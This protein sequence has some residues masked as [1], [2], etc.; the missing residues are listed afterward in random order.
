MD[1]E[2]K[3]KL[4]R[5][6]C[7]IYKDNNLNIDITNLSLTHINNNN[8]KNQL[9]D[10]II[11]IL[12]KL[13][14]KLI[15][16]NKT[17]VDINKV[18]QLFRNELDLNQYS[19]SVIKATSFSEKAKKYT[20]PAAKSKLILNEIRKYFNQK[21]I[22]RKNKIIIDDYK[23]IEKYRYQWN[24]KS[25]VEVYSKTFNKWCLGEIINIF[26]DNEGEWLRV[27]YQ[28]KQKSL[29]RYNQ[30]IRPIQQQQINNNNNN[31]KRRGSIDHRNDKSYNSY[32]VKKD[33]N[34]N[35]KSYWK[36]KEC[37][38]LNH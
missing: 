28:N 11:K 23:D 33:D 18:I 15:E 38:F 21:E 27:K 2:D 14:N 10:T 12:K 13:N 22:K 20:I 4:Y 8:K 35:N 25:K 16:E 7:Q 34:N 29:Q 26:Q 37:G 9:I 36:C 24:I 30:Q 5:I 19:L 3:F 1:E 32:V 6:L 17:I 31:N